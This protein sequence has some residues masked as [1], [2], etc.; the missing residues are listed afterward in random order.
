MYLMFLAE[1]MLSGSISGHESGSNKNKTLLTMTMIEVLKT[2]ETYCCNF[3][4]FMYLPKA[5]ACSVLNLSC[6]F[7]KNYSIFKYILLK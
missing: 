4:I 7:I 1:F 3:N 5:A 2:Q 6:S